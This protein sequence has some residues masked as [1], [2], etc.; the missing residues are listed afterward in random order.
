MTHLIYVF[1]QDA[2]S[3]RKLL[4]IRSTRQGARKLDKKLTREIS[5][6]NFDQF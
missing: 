2:R 5:W 1:A 4:A 3:S 6:P